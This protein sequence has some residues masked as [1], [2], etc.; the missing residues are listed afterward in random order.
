M[1]TNYYIV[2]LPVFSKKTL[3]NAWS[4]CYYIYSVKN[5]NFTLV[6]GSVTNETSIS[7]H[8]GI[9]IKI[10]TLPASR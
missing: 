3:E 1:D 4:R 7:E 5:E 6:G 2:L 8:A 10:E 9:I